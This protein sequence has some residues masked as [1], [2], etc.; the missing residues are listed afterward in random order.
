MRKDN[1]VLKRSVALLD[2]KTTRGHRSVVHYASPFLYLPGVAGELAGAAG[3][4]GAMVVTG[5]GDWKS[6]LAVSSRP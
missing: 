4:A 5:G 1:W 3:V 2:R 6:F